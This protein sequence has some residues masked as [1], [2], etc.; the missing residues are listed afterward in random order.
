MKKIGVLTLDSHSY[1]YGGVLQQYALCHI[2]EEA[3]FDTKII[4]FDLSSE[5]NTFSYKRSLFNLNINKFT[6]RFKQWRKNTSKIDVSSYV[7]L[8]HEKFDQFRTEYLKLSKRY[9]S[10]NISDADN[11]FD[12]F[13]CGS[14]QIWNPGLNIPEFFLDFVLGSQRKIIYGASLGRD[15][16]TKRQLSIYKKMMLDL[17][18]I[19]V[20]ED[21]A[22]TILQPLVSSEIEVVLDP[23]LL[24]QP[25]KWKELV[26]NPQKMDSEYI[27]CHFLDNSTEKQKA[28]NKT[29]QELGLKIVTIPFLH[30]C[31][32]KQSETFGDYRFCEIGPQ[33]FLGLICN[34][35]LVLTDSFH[36]TVFSI[37][38]RKNFWTF[39]RDCGT[40]NMDSRIV[41]LLRYFELS[42]RMV[43]V[44]KEQYNEPCKYQ[45]KYEQFE[46]RKMASLKFLNDA[47]F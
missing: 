36:A 37:L 47:I 39:S 14:D 32:E 9:T 2:L 43:G 31:Y 29:S 1:N 25:N 6:N 16:L 12:L 20:R 4:E 5:I 27:F 34:A 35:N 17:E 30:D 28:A 3:G 11:E 13:I 41:T 42:N 38:F 44:S 45:E 24:V 18:H 46:Q 10:K 21:N 40:Y 19:S 15:E 26:R 8:R 7:S 22:K 33:E 23:I